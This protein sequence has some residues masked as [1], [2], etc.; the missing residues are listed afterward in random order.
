MW[1]AAA[2]IIR[3]SGTRRGTRHAIASNR[4][5]VN[6]NAMRK[7]RS[8][9]GKKKGSAPISP[10]PQTAGQPTVH[11]IPPAAVQAAAV[12]ALALAVRALHLFQMRDSPLFEVLI[13]DAWQ[14]DQ[15]A[16][17]I[18]GGEW[19]GGSE[20]FYQTPLYPY[21]LAVVYAVFGHSIWLVRLGQAVLGSLACVFLARAGSRFFSPPAGWVSGILLAL[22][23]PAIF[24]DAIV[25]KASL[26][27]VL[28]TALLW[29]AAVAQAKP[30]AALFGGAGF[31]CGA[32]TLNREN[33][34]VL[35]PVL[36]A[37]IVWLSWSEPLKTRCA[38][39]LVFFLA[40]AAVLLPVGW[41]NFY[42]G[43]AFLL[44]TSQ[45][46]PN[47]YIGNH[48][49]AQGSYESLRAVRGDPLH[50]SQD[51]RLLAEEAL[52]RRP[53]S[54]TEVSKYWLARSWTDIQSDPASWLRLL[55]WKWFLTWN[56]LELVDAE[57][58]R[59]H[60]QHSAVLAGLGWALHYGILCPLAVLGL[61]LTRRDWRRLWL[62]YALLLIYA[63]A[64]AA[65]Y[66]LAR[67]RYPLVGVTALFAAAGL[68]GLWEKLRGRNSAR[69][70]AGVRDIIIGTALAAV[71]VV[72]CNWPLPNL[73]NDA[74]NYLNVGIQLLNDGRT[75]DG[76][77]MLEQAEK[78]DPKFS[79]TYYG[80]GQASIARG[81]LAQAQHYFEQA[82]ALDPNLAAVY[83]EL[84][85]VVQKQGEQ[86]RAVEYLR[87]AIAIDPLLATA[88]RPLARIE[89][90]RGHAA[91]AIGYLRRAVELEPNS[92]S[93]HSDLG[94]AL[95]AQGQLSD[96]VAELR[97]AVQLDPD[98]A[99][100]A[101]NLAWVLATASDDSIRNSAEA[102]SLAE[103]ICRATDYG[104]PEFLDTLAA[105]YAENGQF[106]KAVEFS[107]KAVELAR[108][109]NRI[110]VARLLEG[111]RQSYLAGRPFRDPVLKPKAADRP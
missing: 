56:T 62:L 48:Q 96:A 91:E 58:I 97:E 82:I 55:A 89:L 13:C 43:G 1:F 42:V 64:V 10:V 50:E 41:R 90:K 29:V 23:P 51:A 67:Y 99:I 28:M 88:Y 32:M 100:V 47:F 107:A 31:L 35:L 94:M 66:V 85:G 3:N 109:D 104:K 70:R 4:W 27:L 46:G 9:A 101:N 72:I 18:A 87:Q 40:M 59:T 49:G 44:T 86:A 75:T 111:R 68:V 16:Q 14:Y 26:D 37:W 69:D 38:R 57:S 102:L 76:I 79:A 65:F 25:Q 8:T 108:G 92:P 39:V 74:V 53:L 7:M 20:V 73:Y 78:I 5:A 36:L 71:A 106:D 63:A 19:L 17:R 33:A 98:A 34:A 84:A 15:W 95:M 30:R 103:K 11:S 52:D 12:F 77:A 83:V 45:M 110:E 54:P 93:A 80:L 60:E 105:A 2:P 6:N 21:C 24:F 22:Y 61:W 81:N